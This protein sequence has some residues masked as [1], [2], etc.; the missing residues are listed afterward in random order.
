MSF[1]MVLF[2]KVN[3][4]VINDMVMG[5]SNG[6]MGQSMKVIGWIIKPMEKEYFIM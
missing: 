5:Y 1:K 4:K 2:I 3:G 6:L